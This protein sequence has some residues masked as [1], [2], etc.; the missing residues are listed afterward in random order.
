[1]SVQ[2]LNWVGV[3]EPVIVFVGAAGEVFCLV[4]VAARLVVM[5]EAAESFVN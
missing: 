5:L 4:G 3:G 1:M 2:P